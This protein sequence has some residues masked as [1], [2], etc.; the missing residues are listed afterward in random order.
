MTSTGRLWFAG[1]YSNVF[2]AKRDPELCEP[3]LA[4]S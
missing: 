3:Q 2:R 4:G 1:L